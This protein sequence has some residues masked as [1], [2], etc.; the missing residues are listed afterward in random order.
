MERLTGMQH[1][2]QQTNFVVGPVYFYYVTNMK[3]FSDLNQLPSAQ[4][5]HSKSHIHVHCCVQLKVFGKQQTV[6]LHLDAERRT[7]SPGTTNKLKRT[8]E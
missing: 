8:D 1:A 7:T 5:K 4:Q 3:C 2:T 6:D